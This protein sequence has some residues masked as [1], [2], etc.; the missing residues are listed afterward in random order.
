MG[1]SIDYRYGL[2]STVAPFL[3][4]RIRQ[5]LQD[6]KQVLWLLSG[7]SGIQVCV[8]ASK[9][10]KDENLTNLYVTIS[11][12]RYGPVGHT[13]ENIQQLLD[14]GL[15]LPGAVIYRP[16]TGASIADTTQQYD[17]WLTDTL[18]NADYTIALLGIGEDG[19]TS[20]IKPHSPAVQSGDLVCHFDGE[21]YQRITTTVSFFSHIDEV[22]V[23]AYGETKRPVVSELLHTP[24]HSLEDFPATLIQN[25]PKVTLFTDFK[26]EEI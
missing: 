26:K 21:D 22:V 6:G 10:L 16:L 17:G 19:H 14:A 2:Q 15:S 24:N 25:I 18:A 4:D 20:G 3:A 11:D 9:L 8:T 23:Q 1:T 7:G 13:N 5:Q 12:E